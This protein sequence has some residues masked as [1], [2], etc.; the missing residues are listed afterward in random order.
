MAAH[1]NPF[2][3]IFDSNTEAIYCIPVASKA[4]SDWDVY[5]AKAILDELGY[6]NV[7][8]CIKCDQAP[9]LLKLRS[10]LG[11]LRDAPTVPIDVPARE[12][13]AN[14]G[15]ERAVRTW[16]GQFRT[17]KPHLEYE[18]KSTLPL[19]HYLPVGR[20]YLS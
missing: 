17:L 5:F 12:S 10:E 4:A 13:N 14:G 9:E 20:W 8:V 19:H 11:K 1:S 18:L 16:A 6:E 3:I 15:M 7:K 2:L